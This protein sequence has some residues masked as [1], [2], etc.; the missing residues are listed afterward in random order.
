MKQI[1][2]QLIKVFTYMNIYL[3]NISC[4]SRVLII[5][6]VLQFPGAAAFASVMQLYMMQAVVHLYSAGRVL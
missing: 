1:F 2:S 3:W 5:A 4:Y 6:V